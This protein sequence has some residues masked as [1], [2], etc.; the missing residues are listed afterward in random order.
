M[1]GMNSVRTIALTLALIGPMRKR[2]GAS[3]DA[4]GFWRRSIMTGV[5]GQLLSRVAETG[6]PDEAFTAGLLTDIG[7]LTIYETLPEEYLQLV[8]R[9][10]GPFVPD[11]ELERD[12][13]GW[14]HAEI[15]AALLK[16]LGLP[17]SFCEKIRCHHDPVSS[18]G[19]DPASDDGSIHLLQIAARASSILCGEA[20]R[21]EMESVRGQME[22]RLGLEP[23][24]VRSVVENA[25]QTVNEM[26]RLL[27]IDLGRVP[28]DELTKATIGAA[29]EG[30]D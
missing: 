8:A 2:M 14:T 3:F 1:L 10:G 25:G 4:T 22:D 28:T 11:C 16:Q 7:V 19:D 24:R 23:E 26:A 20:E 6:R 13:L 17:E 9:Q 29:A 5:I 18:A 15:G 21:E 30:S 12:V 27:E